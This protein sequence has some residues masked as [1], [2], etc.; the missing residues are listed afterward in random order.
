MFSEIT[1]NWRGRPLE[2]LEV[3]VEL[4][5]HT[6][7]EG[8]LTIRAAIDERPY[9]TG[10]KITAAELGEVQLE[11]AAFRGEWNYTIRPRRER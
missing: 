2:S 11:P 8:G 5:A 1:K 9:Q 3:I 4:I 6:H 7:T 10:I